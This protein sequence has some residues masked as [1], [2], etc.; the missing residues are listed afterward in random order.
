MPKGD[1]Q[2]FQRFVEHVGQYGAF[3]MPPQAFDQIQ[4]RTVWRQPKDSKLLAMQIKKFKDGFRLM[5][6]AVVADEHNGAT[7]IAFQQGDQEQQELRP[8][9]VIRNRV[10]EF[11]APIV[12]AP[13]HDTFL[14][15]PGG[16]NFRLL[17][18]RCPAACQSGVAVDFHLVLKNQDCLASFPGRPF[19][20]RLSSAWAST[21]LVSS[22]LPFIVCL[23]RWKEKPS[24][25]SNRRTRS[26]LN[27][28]RV[29]FFRWALSRAADHTLKPYPNC[30]GG[31]I[32]ALRKA[33][34]YSAVTRGGRP[35][36]LSGV[37]PVMP[38]SRY[39]LRTLL[40]VAA[41]HPNSSAIENRECPVPRSDIRMIKQL[42]NT[43]A[44][45]AESRRRSSSSHCS[46]DNLKRPIAHLRDRIHSL[47]IV[48]GELKRT[49]TFRGPT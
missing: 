14:V 9:L 7:G 6:A 24:S 45:P 32:T 42:R 27:C 31:V 20:S 15:L 29:V 17:A 43:F 21:Y 38:C 11:A 25:R 47:P 35:V 19:F 26:S 12:H 8:A 10:G 23:G 30:W 36:D 41:L 5:E 3:D 13:I 34:R 22:R 40:T 4:A 48:Y 33:A 16:G 1:L 46:S 39:R 49:E 28:S 44:S 2:V 37:S 18:H